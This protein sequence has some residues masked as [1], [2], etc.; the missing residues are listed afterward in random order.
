MNPP[1][2]VL[3]VVLCYNAARHIAEVLDRI[4]ANPSADS[5]Y[6]IEVRIIDDASSDETA[7]VAR[8]YASHEHKPYPVVTHRENRG[9]GGSQKQA[10][11]MATQEGFAALALLHGD[12][13]YPPEM[14]DALV[15]PLLTGEAD[16]VFGTRMQP[17]AAA[18][19]GGMPRYKFYGNRALTWMQNRMLGTRLTE[20]H[21]GFRA[22]ATAALSGLDYH[23]NSDDFDFDTQI[24]LQLLGKEKRILEIPI[25]TRYADEVCHVNC[26][27]YGLQVLRA[28]LRFT[29]RRRDKTGA[30]R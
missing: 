2:K 20:F 15:A 13:Q 16:A 19:E 12:G 24:I 18:L 17:P 11:D 28:T 22:Y 8:I 4:P 21:C 10:M 23:A 6:A 25:P 29:I 30:D 3:V 1:Q 9:Y 7:T 5:R 26:L 14:L 27:K